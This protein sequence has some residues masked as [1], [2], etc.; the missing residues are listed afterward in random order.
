[1]PADKV[2]VVAAIHAHNLAVVSLTASFILFA[3][4]FAC[5]LTLAFSFPQAAKSGKELCNLYR[6]FQGAHLAE[7]EVHQLAAEQLTNRKADL[8]S[9]ESKLKKAE[10]DMNKV[11]ADLHSRIK[12]SKGTPLT[13]PTRM[14]RLQ[15]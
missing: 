5:L 14:L 4:Y 13:C 9:T 10:A 7:V 11:K 1:M 15:N 3:I 2:K 8:E 12:R 6:H